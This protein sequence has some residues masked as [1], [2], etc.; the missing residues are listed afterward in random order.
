MQAVGGRNGK[1]FK[2]QRSRFKVPGQPPMRPRLVAAFAVHSAF[3]TPHS[4]FARLKSLPF[5]QSPSRSLVPVPG[6]QGRFP[7]SGRPAGDAAFVARLEA[8]A[9]RILA[10]TS[11][12]R[13]K[14]GKRPLFPLFL[15]SGPFRM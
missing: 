2:A 7:I 9:G 4:S 3:R 8:L 15:D 5:W 1:R 10:A 6:N 12:G 14:I 13:P 11:V